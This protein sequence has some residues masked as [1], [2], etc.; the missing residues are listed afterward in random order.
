[1]D[2][3]HLWI[4]HYLFRT[5]L[6]GLLLYLPS[7]ITE[8]HMRSL[9]LMSDSFCD[10]LLHCVSFLSVCDNETRRMRSLALCF[11]VLVCKRSPFFRT[12]A[13]CF[14]FALIFS[15]ITLFWVN[16]SVN[17]VFSFFFQ[18][19]TNQMERHAGGLCVTELSRE[20][21]LCIFSLYDIH[22][23]STKYTSMLNEHRWNVMSC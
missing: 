10:W 2:Y 8:L 5:T 22:G 3:K 9:A 19:N 20:D 14:H 21:K 7:L 15:F 11:V 4:C 12:D 18:E 16:Y 17:N 1:M 13:N 23:F 6:K